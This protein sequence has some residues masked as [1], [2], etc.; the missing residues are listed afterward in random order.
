MHQYQN[1]LRPSDIFRL[2]QKIMLR[3]VRQDWNVECDKLCYE[4][5]KKVQ[6]ICQRRIRYCRVR[7]NGGEEKEREE[8]EKGGGE[9]RGE[10]RIETNGID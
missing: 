1:I 10:E 2:V 4:E 3:K 5:K 7:E 9:R 8:E 6:W